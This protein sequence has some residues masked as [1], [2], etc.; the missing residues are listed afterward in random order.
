MVG[1][2]GNHLTETKIDTTDR[3]MD[4]QNYAA[5]LMMLGFVCFMAGMIVGAWVAI[6]F[7]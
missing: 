4:D 7:F 6:Q 1:G 3:A 5:F 2:I